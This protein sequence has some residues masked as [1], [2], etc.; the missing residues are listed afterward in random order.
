MSLR[1]SFAALF[2][3][4]ILKTTKVPESPSMVWKK[5]ARPSKLGAMSKQG[6]S[7]KSSAR[8]DK[9]FDSKSTLSLSALRMLHPTPKAIVEGCI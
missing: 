3:S 1:E 6:P 5:V 4:I 9:T 7:T 2:Q 8:Q